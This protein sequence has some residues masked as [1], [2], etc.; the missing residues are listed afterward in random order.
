MAAWK[1]GIMQAG[2][3]IIQ[4]LDPDPEAH[5]DSSNGAGIINNFPIL[6]VYLVTTPFSSTTN[7]IIYEII[8]AVIITAF[9]FCAG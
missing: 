9:S 7:K 1:I 8:A 3:N 5:D 4:S 2:V 6:V